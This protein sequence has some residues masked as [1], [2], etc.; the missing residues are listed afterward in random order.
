MPRS[1]GDA[2]INAEF[3]VAIA[4]LL[5]V[6]L[7]IYM[8][9]HRSVLDALDQRSARIRAELDEALR[10]KEEAQKLVAEYRR[11]H[12]EAE[13][14]AE[15]IIAEAKAEAERVAAESKAKM[16][17]FVA[18]RTK[19]A[20]SKIGQAEAQALAD[21]RAAAAEAAVT[22]AEKILRDTTKGQVA[23]NLIARGIADVKAKLN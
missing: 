15:A 17:E 6:A 13:R 2:M 10:L 8:G 23:D 19:L 16:E 3:W 5:F 1:N 18:R 22:A 14:E 20:E 9:V 7:L 21:V 12:E 4:F 11:K